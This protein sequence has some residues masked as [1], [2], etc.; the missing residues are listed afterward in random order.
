VTDNS[1]KV[2]H[3]ALSLST[4]ER[5]ELAG[6]LLD[7]LE[8]ATEPPPDVEQAWREEVASR[9]AA[10]DA[11]QVETVTWDE[12]RDRMFATLGERRAG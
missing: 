12:V 1:K 2:L 10:L 5:A 8:P 11:R 9:V 3:Q 6:A 4:E 7:S